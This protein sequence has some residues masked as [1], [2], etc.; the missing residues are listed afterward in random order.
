MVTVNPATVYLNNTNNA[1][2]TEPYYIKN[3]VEH[4]YAFSLTE[5]ETYMSLALSLSLSLTHT[6]THIKT[7]TTIVQQL[8]VYW[9]AS[10]CDTLKELCMTYRVIQ[11]ERS[12]FR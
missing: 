8:L 12:I 6:H 9:T 1:N 10:R 2:S 5:G 3:S 11:E 4:T 7:C